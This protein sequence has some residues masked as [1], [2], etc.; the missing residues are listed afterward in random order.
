MREEFSKWFAEAFRMFQINRTMSA[1]YRLDDATLSDIGL[2]R[3]MISGY[4][5]DMY[6]R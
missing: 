2:R 3:N 5:R 6:P 4:V 1:L